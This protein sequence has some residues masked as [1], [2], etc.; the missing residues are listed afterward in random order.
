MEKIINQILDLPQMLNQ[1]LPKNC[2]NEMMDNSEG[3]VSDWTGKIFKVGALVVLVGMV[4]SVVNGGMDAVNGADGLGKVAAGLCTL[5]LIYAAFP[6]AQVVR[7]AGDSLAA[8]KKLYGRFLFKDF[9]VA[10]IKAAWT[11]YGFSSIIWSNL[12][13]SWMGFGSE[14]CM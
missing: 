1:K 12:F 7:S 13:T 9:I 4:M 3:S 11:Y 2:F 5:I 8:S 10:N 6:I 14:E